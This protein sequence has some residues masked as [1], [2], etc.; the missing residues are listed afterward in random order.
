MCDAFMHFFLAVIAAAAAAAADCGS[1]SSSFVK[2]VIPFSCTLMA[3]ATLW[4][5]PF[6]LL[7]Q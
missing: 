4:Q 5:A 7:L 1:S 2:Q 6:A 3:T